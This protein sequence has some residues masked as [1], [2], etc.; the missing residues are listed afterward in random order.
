MQLI[1]AFS[2]GRLLPKGFSIRSSRG[3]AFLPPDEHSRAKKACQEAIRLVLFLSGQL[4][5]EPLEPRDPLWM[6]EVKLLQDEDI[7]QAAL[8]CNSLL[9]EIECNS[10]RII[11]YQELNAFVAAFRM[12][13]LSF[14]KVYVDFKE[15]KNQLEENHAVLQ[16]CRRKFKNLLKEIA[17]VGMFIKCNF[18]FVDSSKYVEDESSLDVPLD[19]YLKEHDD[20]RIAH[21]SRQKAQKKKDLS[22]AEFNSVKGDFDV[23]F[24]CIRNI[25]ILVARGVAMYTGL[26]IDKTSL[27]S[28]EPDHMV[29]STSKAA[30]KIHPFLFGGDVTSADNTSQRERVVAHLINDIPWKTLASLV[31]IEKVVCGTLS[32]RLVAAVAAKLS[33]KLQSRL[34]PWLRRSLHDLIQCLRWYSVKE[35][36]P[37]NYAKETSESNPNMVR[38]LMTLLEEKT[39]P[40]PKWK[41]FKRSPNLDTRIATALSYWCIRGNTAMAERVLKWEEVVNGV[42][43]KGKYIWKLL[44][45]RAEE[46][47]SIIED[48]SE[49]YERTD[50]TRVMQEMNKITLSRAM[51]E[52]DSDVDSDSDSDTDSNSDDEDDRC[53][54]DDENG[55]C[56]S[57]ED[58]EILAFLD[59]EE[60]DHIM[61]VVVEAR[62][63]SVI[64]DLL[65]DEYAL[66]V[67][68]CSA[69]EIVLDDIPEINIL[70]DAKLLSTG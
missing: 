25:G 48:A 6:L 42:L 47:S 8:A 21:T 33:D 9:Y 30:S 40:L 11:L 41:N 69:T 60:E 59:P 49:Y 65:L 7:K 54:T 53:S 44:V 10:E 66:A 1:T 31:H 32:L 16:K 63:S 64:D 15:K 22:H 18:S 28:I 12:R 5:K 70:K 20:L 17:R 13:V 2:A 51:N 62:H 67:L 24:S 39:S 4:I 19:H 3:K 27:L 14:E 52:L 43:Q 34:G 58:E 56:S 26:Y 29:P 36:I 23:L 37:E 45:E 35:D 38:G 50:P 57:E 46:K 68:H 61:S 55:T